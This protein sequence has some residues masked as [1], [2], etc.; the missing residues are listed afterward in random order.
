M[1]AFPIAR[2]LVPNRAL[3]LPPGFTRV[4][5][6]LGS[7]LPHTL[8][9][10][11][12]VSVTFA[13]ATGL[14]EQWRRLPIDTVVASSEGETAPF[15]SNPA[16][17]ALPATARGGLLVAVRAGTRVVA[18]WPLVAGAVR[19]LARGVAGNAPVAFV[20]VSWSLR[21]GN[22]VGPGELGSSIVFGHRRLDRG[23]E[24]FSDPPPHLEVQARLARGAKYMESEVGTALIGTDAQ[25]AS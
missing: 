13:L 21:A 25:G 6:S 7:G 24:R 4:E 12:G 5:S 10:S 2:Y 1:P 23:A 19:V 22:V 20:A 17:D 8:A 11:A 15:G 14:A 9:L 3:A 16:W 18:T